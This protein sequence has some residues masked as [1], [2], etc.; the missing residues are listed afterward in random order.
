M[1]FKEAKTEFGQ[2]FIFDPS[3]KPEAGQAWCEFIDCLYRDGRITVKQ[4]QSWGNP[5]YK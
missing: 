4:V 3:D 5:F 1:T 2:R